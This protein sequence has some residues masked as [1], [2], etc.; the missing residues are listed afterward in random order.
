MQSQ[1]WL[2]IK[3]GICISTV[4]RQLSVASCTCHLSDHLSIVRLTKI[5]QSFYLHLPTVALHFC[6]TEGILT[7]WFACIICMSLLLWQSQD[8]R[9][10]LFQCTKEGN[11]WNILRQKQTLLRFPSVGLWFRE[12]GGGSWNYDIWLSLTVIGR[13]GHH[14]SHST[15]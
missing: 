12:E 11:L 13:V 14:H 10:H 4:S 2:G 7:S 5:K 1:K 9:Q 3:G 8:L 6:S 15:P